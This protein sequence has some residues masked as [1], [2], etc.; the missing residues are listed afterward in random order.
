M[1]TTDEL[2]DALIR[3]CK[4]PE[5]LIGENG[6]LKLLS[7]KSMERAMP[8]EMTESLDCHILHRRKVDEAL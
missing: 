2:L 6:L 4:K 7:K 5:D 1:A 3:D 8:A